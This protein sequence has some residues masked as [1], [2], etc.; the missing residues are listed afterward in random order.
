LTLIAGLEVG[1]GWQGRIRPMSGNAVLQRLHR[2]DRAGRGQPLRGERGERRDVVA[3]APGDRIGGS[4]ADGRAS[5]VP[6]VFD[7]PINGTC[8]SAHVEQVLVPTLA[9]GDISLPPAKAGVII[10]LRLDG[11]RPPYSCFHRS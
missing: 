2:G 9:P 8:F 1:I 3:A 11:P 10:V 4:T 5:D 7:G 6:C